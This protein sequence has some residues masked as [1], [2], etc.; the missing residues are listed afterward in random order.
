MK[1][2]FHLLTV[3]LLFAVSCASKVAVQKNQ[4]ELKAE[5]AIVS[6]DAVAPLPMIVPILAP[7]VHIDDEMQLGLKPIFAKN[8][9]ENFYLVLTSYKLTPF[10]ASKDVI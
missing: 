7:E 9:Q 1:F 2:Y 6:P 10:S 8:F 4:P 3:T 5:E